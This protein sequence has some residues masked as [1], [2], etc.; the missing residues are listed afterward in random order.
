[1][2]SVSDSVQNSAV[3]VGIDEAGR[4]AL[5]GPVVAGACLLIPE[6]EGHPLIADSKSLSFEQRE[7]VFGW[8]EQHCTYGVGIVDGSEVDQHGILACTEKAMQEALAMVEKSVTPTYL[9]IDGRDKFWFNYPKSGV[10]RGDES[11]PCI[12][13]GSIVAK[14]TRDRMMIEYAK[15]YPKYGFAEH[16][17]YGAP[18]HIEALEMFGVCPLH[19]KTF[20]RNITVGQP[21]KS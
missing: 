20:L 14:V 1:M 6:L 21:S 16:K 12:S 10:I 15:E 2:S 4:G 17:G 13:A 3:I 8:I 7:E 18:Q 5:A 9:L 11:E 19:R